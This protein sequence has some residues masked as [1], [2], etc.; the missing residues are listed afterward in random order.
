MPIEA[1]QV[2]LFEDGEGSYR[3]TFERLLPLKSEDPFDLTVKE[4]EAKIAGGRKPKKPAILKTLLE[5]EIIED[6]QVLWYHPSQL[7]ADAKHVWSPDNIAFRVV[8]DVSTGKPLFRWKP[9]EDAPE[10]LLSPSMAWFS[11]MDAVLPGRYTT[12]IG[13]PVFNHYSLEAGG[14]T[15][16]DIAHENG[17]W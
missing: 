1:V 16:E 15:L 2:Q 10:E 7:T 3:L 4:T 6:G 14:P 9:I 17:L 8:L 12:K 13:S 5:N 11:I